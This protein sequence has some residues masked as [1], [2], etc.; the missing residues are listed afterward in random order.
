MKGLLGL[1]VLSGG[2]LASLAS[3]VGL[4]GPVIRTV[5]PEDLVVLE[6][7][8]DGPVSDEVWSCK[9]L[10]PMGILL[11]LCEGIF[12]R[13]VGIWWTCELVIG[14][15]C[16]VG[17]SMPVLAVSDSVCVCDESAMTSAGQPSVVLVSSYEVLPSVSSV[18]HSLS[19]G[20]GMDRLLH[21]ITCSLPCNQV[22]AASL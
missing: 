12:L 18:L 2:M 4:D 21:M 6:A 3:V 1:D 22:K 14:T 16:G 8:S 20:K 5:L 19:L 15:A 10:F 17:M 9:D 11:C 13:V 7:G